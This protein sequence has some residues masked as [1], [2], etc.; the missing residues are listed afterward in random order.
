MKGIEIM[1]RFHNRSSQGG[2]CLTLKEGQRVEIANGEIIVEVIEIRGNC[3][4][5]S[6]KA[7]KDIPI[8]REGANRTFRVP[9]SSDPSDKG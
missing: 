9:D 6:F 4:R 7:A 2:L 5:V 8:L 3:V 1:G